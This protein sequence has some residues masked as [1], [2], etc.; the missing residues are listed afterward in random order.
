MYGGSDG[1]VDSRFAADF[2]RALTASGSESL[3]EEVENA[4]HN[5][6][7]DPAWVG[8]LIVVWLER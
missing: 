8:D 5:E 3:V 1:I 2:H 7:R 4:L 6:M